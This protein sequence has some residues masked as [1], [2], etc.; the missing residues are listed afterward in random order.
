MLPTL[1][2]LAIWLILVLASIGIIVYLVNGVRKREVLCI[3]ALVSSLVCL[4]TAFVFLA[5]SDNRSKPFSYLLLVFS[6]AIVAGALWFSLVQIIAKMYSQAV[7][8]NGNKYHPKSY[9][10]WWQGTLPST[11]YLGYL[12]SNLIGRPHTVVSFWYAKI[13]AIAVVGIVFYKLLKTAKE[14]TNSVSEYRRVPIT[15][16]NSPLIWLSL[17]VIFLITATRV[18]LE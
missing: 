12:L 15:V 10:I 4:L 2:G 16:V 5:I 17:I 1:G 3:R 13:V 8:S 7:S 6:P 18:W 14:N 9:E 11:V